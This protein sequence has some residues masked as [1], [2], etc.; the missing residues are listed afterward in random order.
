MNATH[1]LTGKERISKSVLNFKNRQGFTLIEL[2]VVIVILGILAAIL[3][4]VLAKA[5]YRAQGVQ[6][7]TNQKQ[8][9]LGFRMYADDNADVMLSAVT[10][11]NTSYNGRPGW[12][13]GQVDFSTAQ[14]N[15][16]INVYLTKSPLWYY[17]PQA[18][19]YRCPADPVVVTVNAP[20]P[21]YRRGQYPRI[22]SISLSQVYGTGDW[23]PG[24]EYKLYSRFT[25]IDLPSK[26]TTFV[27]EHPNS[28]N[29]AAWG[30]SD[31]PQAVVDEPA[32]FHNGHAAGFAFADGHAEI[33]KWLG[34]LSAPAYIPNN[35]TPLGPGR[36]TPTIDAD[37]IDVAW[38]CANNA[39]RQ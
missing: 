9:M 33:H 23:Q 39:V 38:V 1:T 30:W 34:W 3:L 29:D 35:T 5:K 24:G 7:I 11:N 20:P 15:W 31:D 6:C 27:D 16:D 37:I 12:I 26:S 32:P 25:T 10:G 13:S 18:P 36:K 22:R 4:P 28:I 14:G 17:A 21:G 2:L 8:V 19:I